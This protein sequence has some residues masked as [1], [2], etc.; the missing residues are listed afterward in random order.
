MWAAP[1]AGQHGADGGEWRFY[2]GD[3]GPTLRAYDKGTGEVLAELVLPANPTAPPM[4]YMLDGRHYIAVA[5]ATLETPAEII[6][7]ALP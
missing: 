1:A 4:S 2:A 3:G 5:A 7:L 6:A